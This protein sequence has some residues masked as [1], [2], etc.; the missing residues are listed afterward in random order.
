V[1][2]VMDKQEVD[3][4]S[5]NREKAKSW[6]YQRDKGGGSLLDYLGYGTTL[7]TWYL[8]GKAPLEVT[9]LVDRPQGLDVD[10]HSITVVRYDS[11]LSK[12]ETRWGTFTDPWTLQPQ[13]KCGFVLVGRAGTISSYDYEK[14]VRV[15]TKARPEGFDIPVDEPRPPLDNPVN[16][17]IDSLDRNAPVEGPLSP[18]IARIGQQIVDAALK[19]A[20]ERRS[21]AFA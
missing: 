11:G 2:H 6:F 13:P 3:E 8:N 17:M 12:Y 4:L 15:Q 14:T 1:R 16:Y 20:S 10:E 5:A 9:A 7:G 18:A 19:S 21:V